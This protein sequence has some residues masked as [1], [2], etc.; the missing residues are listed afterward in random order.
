MNGKTESDIKGNARSSLLDELYQG[1]AK[2]TITS[3]ASG[4]TIEIPTPQAGEFASEP[5]KILGI[6]LALTHCL[7]KDIEEMKKQ[8]E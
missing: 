6:S 4:K 8:K 5:D 3:T 1:T 2:I 7:L